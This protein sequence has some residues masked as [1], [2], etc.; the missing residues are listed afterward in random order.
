MYER[1]ERLGEDRRKEKL[2]QPELV[3]VMAKGTSSQMDQM[4]EDM[5]Q[6]M[7]DDY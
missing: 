1:Q 3:T 7:W 2:E 4:R 6:K 5:A